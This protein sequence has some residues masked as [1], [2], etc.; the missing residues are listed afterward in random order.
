MISPTLCPTSAPLS[1]SLCEFLSFP[2]GVRNVEDF[3]DID[4]VMPHGGI[5]SWGS[6][7]AGRR[8]FHMRFTIC[9]LKII[10]YTLRLQDKLKVANFALDFIEQGTNNFLQR[11]ITE[12]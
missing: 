10:M 6:R 11:K 2:F 3:G 12:V 7:G 8:K 5:W 4:C 9:L 1:L